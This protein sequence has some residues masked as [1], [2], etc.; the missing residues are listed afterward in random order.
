MFSELFM[1]HSL[2]VQHIFIQHDSAQALS[3]APLY[4]TFNPHSNTARCV[5]SSENEGTE[6]PRA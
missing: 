3:E 6:T 1:C 4:P 5:L 2:I